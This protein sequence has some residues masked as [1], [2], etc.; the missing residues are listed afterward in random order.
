MTGATAAAPKYALMRGLKAA[1]THGLIGKTEKNLRRRIETDLEY[2]LNERRE[3]G[4]VLDKKRG[5]ARGLGIGPREEI[6]R[7]PGIERPRGIEAAPG[8]RQ[9][10]R[11]LIGENAAARGRGARQHMRET[12]SEPVAARVDPPL[13]VNRSPR[14][15]VSIKRKERLGNKKKSRS[16]R[17]R[18]RHILPPNARLA[19][20]DSPS[21]ASTIRKAWA[22]ALQK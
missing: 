19:R 12:A 21:P 8:H 9:T 18:P 3:V 16:A 17:G 5:I 20:K 14:H 13:P 22:T 2:V 15:L 7:A 1:L 10:G 6:K 11:N 4:L